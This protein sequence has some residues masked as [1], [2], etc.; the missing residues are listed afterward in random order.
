MLFGLIFCA[1]IYGIIAFILIAAAVL[2]GAS[3]NE[4]ENQIRLTRYGKGTFPA[5]MISATQAV[6]YEGNHYHRIGDYFYDDDNNQYW[7]I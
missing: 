1:L 7:E 4:D 2:I 3:G 6:D 5:R